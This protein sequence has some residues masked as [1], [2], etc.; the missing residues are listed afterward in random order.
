MTRAILAH[1]WEVTDMSAHKM[2]EA[3]YH[4]YIVGR[5]DGLADWKAN[6]DYRPGNRRDMYPV[7][8]CDGWTAAAESEFWESA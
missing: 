1:S 2:T 4:V 6:R 5:A 3:E 8:Y 7:G